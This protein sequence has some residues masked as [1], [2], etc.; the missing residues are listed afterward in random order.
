LRGRGYISLGEIAERLPM[1]RVTCDRCGRAGRYSTAKL[2][3]KYGADASI[4]PLQ[5]EI[6]ADCPRRTDPKIELGKGCAPVCQ[7]L[8]K[9]F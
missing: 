9:V 7:D 3:A 4:E 8:S 1:L 5:Q 2:V 6:T